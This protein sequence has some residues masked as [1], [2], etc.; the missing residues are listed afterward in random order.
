M[1]VEK[2][3]SFLSNQSG[4]AKSIPQAKVSAETM[5]AKKATQEDAATV[6]A[7]TSGAGGTTSGASNPPKRRPHRGKVPGVRVHGGLG[8]KEGADERGSMLPV[9]GIRTSGK[10]LGRTC[11][12]S[13]TS[14]R[15][16][17]T[18]QKQQGRLSGKCVGWK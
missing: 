3:M 6:P 1:E 17:N 8:K 4:T 13:T 12:S 14:R 16:E 18:K 11:R 9:R 15:H 10:T 7:A 2:S 5:P